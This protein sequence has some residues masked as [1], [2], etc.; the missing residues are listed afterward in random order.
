MNPFVM[1]SRVTVAMVFREIDARYG[2]KPGGYLW[3]FVDPVAYIVLLT[4]VREA[5]SSVAPI[6]DSIALFI[7]SGYIAYF[8][9]Q[10]VSSYIAQAVKGNKRLL[11]YPVI[12]AFDVVMGRFFLQ[13]ITLVG[14]AVC[15]LFVASFDAVRQP[16][17]NIFMMLQAGLVAALFGFGVGLS[18]VAL[19]AVWPFYEKVFGMIMR[20]MFLLSGVF[21][22][23][24]EIPPPYQAYLLYNPV[25]HLVM[26]FRKGIYADYRAGLLDIT[27]VMESTVF[28]V[29]AGLILFT[30][31][32]R[33]IKEDS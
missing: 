14:I 4:L 31:C 19:F 12:S 20:P 2:N 8:C 5:L 6:G 17:F 10:S 7:A 16:H 1:F 30:A 23:P 11:S 3:A 9:F 29:M 25:V 28:V 32:S 21:M 22:L 18:N 27:Y 15:I 13:L 26:W 33:S 24:D